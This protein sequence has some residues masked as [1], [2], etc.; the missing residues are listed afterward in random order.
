MFFFYCN[1]N[2]THFQQKGFACSESEG[3]GSRKWPKSPGVEFLET[4]PK[5]RK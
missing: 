4:A 1:V 3:F 5:F 2:K